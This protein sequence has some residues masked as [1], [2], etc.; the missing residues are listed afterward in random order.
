MPGARTVLVRVTSGNHLPAVV[1]EVE[2]YR[3]GAHDAVHDRLVEIEV[4]YDGADLVEV[5][6]ATG[7]SIG[8]LVRRHSE[9]EYTAAFGGFAPGFVYLTGLDPALQLPRRSTPRPSVPAG[10]VAI[11]SE[12]TGVYPTS[13]PGGWH[14]LGTTE[15]VLWDPARPLPSLITP[16]DRVRFVAVSRGA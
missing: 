3:P 1:A 8:E 16:G 4:R 5:A 12:F 9:R 2:T 13:S 7:C 11:A 15:A 6:G 10:S 14:L